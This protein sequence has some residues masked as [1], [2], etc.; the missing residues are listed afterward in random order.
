M[1]DLLTP[2]FTELQDLT[3]ES[4]GNLDEMLFIEPAAEV[5]TLDNLLSESMAAQ[6]ERDKYKQIRKNL[7]EGK[8]PTAERDANQ[9]LLRQWEA[10]R[11]WNKAADV[12]GFERCRCKGCGQFHTIFMGYFEKQTHRSNTSI[13]RWVSVT[14]LSGSLPKEVRYSDHDVP[15]C[16]DCA[17][18]AGF[19]VEE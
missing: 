10:K 6:A 16:E 15:T 1:S 5:F 4:V 12:I 18:F 14:K 9:E 13:S 19:P 17:D 8:V 7:A 2:D 3:D 11:E